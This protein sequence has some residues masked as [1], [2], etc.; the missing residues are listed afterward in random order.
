MFKFSLCENPVI[1]WFSFN[2]HCSSMQAPQTAP[3]FVQLRVI[4]MVIRQDEQWH[5]EARFSQA[6]L[7]P[8]RV[9]P[10]PAPEEENHVGF[11]RRHHGNG[12][13][14]IRALNNDVLCRKRTFQQPGEKLRIAVTN[15]YLHTLFVSPRSP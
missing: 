4:A 15:Q 1:L 9:Y 5:L 3:H 2:M 7:E 6:A 14:T 8:V 11:G 10:E 13:A 12:V